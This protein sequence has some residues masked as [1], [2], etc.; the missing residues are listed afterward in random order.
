MPLVRFI[1]VRVNVP[2]LQIMD[3]I[4]FTEAT[5]LT[6]TVTVKVFP[7]QVPEIGVIE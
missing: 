6:V 1:G 5:G 2:P 4:A 3:V 7:V